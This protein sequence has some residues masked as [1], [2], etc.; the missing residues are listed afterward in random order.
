ME[1]I[2]DSVLDE[3]EQY[4][5]ARYKKKFFIKNNSFISHKQL[6][7][8]KEIKEKTNQTFVSDCFERKSPLEDSL[9][10]FTEVICKTCGKQFEKKCS[11]TDLMYII[12]GILKPECNECKKQAQEIKEKE[13][14]E[15]ENQRQQREINKTKN[16]TNNFLQYVTVGNTWKNTIP[17]YK[18][19]SL[20]EK[21]AIGVDLDYIADV[22][23]SNLSYTDFLKTPY[24]E[25]ISYKKKQLA[26]FRCELCNNNGYLNVHHRTYKYHGYE[27]Y[28][29][30][31]LI[32][33]CN[34]CHKKFHNIT[35]QEETD[36]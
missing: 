18:R 19:F 25:A 30:D 3:M 31:D 13:M 32:V 2:E 28:H 17:V 27:L 4:C 16:I 6:Q 34:D 20:L 33:L 15:W 24:W 5:V 14:Q 7:R 1:V 10:Y 21:D 8:L 12:T 26:G 11:K 9:K 22:I 23:K 35:D 36:E 29:M